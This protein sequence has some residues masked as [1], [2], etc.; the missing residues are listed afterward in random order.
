MCHKLERLEGE[1]KIASS[2]S[3]FFEWAASLISGEGSRHLG[4]KHADV[5]IAAGLVY[6]HLS[7]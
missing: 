5:G 6:H 3:G 7:A 2:L 4:M 1:E